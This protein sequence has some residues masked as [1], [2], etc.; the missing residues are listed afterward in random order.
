MKDGQFILTGSAVPLIDED[1]LNTMHTGTG[2]IG[3]IKM[4]TMSLWESGFTLGF[5]N[6]EVAKSF[7]DALLP[8]YSYH[9]KETTNDVCIK[10]SRYIIN[11]EA[12][13]FMEELKTFL[14]GNPYGLTELDKR[15]KYFQSC[16]YLM[17]RAIGFEPNAELQTCNAR[18]DMMLKT[19]RFIYIFELKTDSSAEEA[20]NQI[21]EK[22]Y[23][24][25]YIKSGKEVI[26][27]GANYS[28]STNNI[29]R[30]IIE[31]IL[32]T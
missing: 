14:H 6:L 17:L 13:L 29:E 25:P 32:A 20:L 2:R 28:S 15:E 26:K 18:M 7:T 31:K 11:G 9:D 4:R 16:L 3:R 1:E 10:M 5:P 19:S 30:W 8:I 22:G 24:L 12:Q 21:D 23:Y 27:I